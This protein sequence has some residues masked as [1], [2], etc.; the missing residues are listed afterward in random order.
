MADTLLNVCNVILLNCGERPIVNTNNTMGIRIKSVIRSA[1]TDVQTLYDWSWSR[2]MVTASS[3]SGNVA[4]VENVQRL[5]AVHYVSTYG[6]YQVKYEPFNSLRRRSLSVGR[7]NYYSVIDE[8]HFAVLPYPDTV[9]TQ[10]SV[11]FDII[12]WTDPPINDSDVFVDIP[13]AFLDLLIKRGS[14]MFATQHNNDLAL[15]Q[16][17]NTEYEALAQ[18]L[19][20]RYRNTPS[21][22]LNMYRGYR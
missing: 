14:G 9:D 20:D 8:E 17:F 10:N 22:G 13:N 1:L 3:W 18:R 15:A 4:T 16:A 19:R 11:L 6:E 21:D 5:K 7:P 2:K 12:Q